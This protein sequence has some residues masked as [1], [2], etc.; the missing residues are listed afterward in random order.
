MF[1]CLVIKVVCRRPLF[2]TASIIYHISF[3]LSRTFFKFFNFLFFQIFSKSIRS[4]ILS[5]LFQRLGYYTM[6]S[7]IC[8]QLFL[9]FWK[10]FK[11]SVYQKQLFPTAQL[12]YYSYTPLSTII[13]KNTWHN[14]FQ[15]FT[16]IWHEHKNDCNIRKWNY[17]LR[18]SHQSMTEIMIL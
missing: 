16:K 2:A 5:A 15:K 17:G 7:V 11:L 3:A 1:H 6:L 9:F 10:T 12:F 8:Q 14:N 18:N 13:F 4:V